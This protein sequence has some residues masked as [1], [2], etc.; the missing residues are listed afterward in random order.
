MSL[1]K[2]PF[3]LMSLVIMAVVCM[4]SFSYPVYAI[5]ISLFFAISC[6]VKSKFFPSGSDGFGVDF[7]LFIL[8][9]WIAFAF[10]CIVWLA[11]L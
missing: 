8:M 11:R 3:L 10:S 2:E 5:F 9:S 1:F 6:H 7:L 4:L